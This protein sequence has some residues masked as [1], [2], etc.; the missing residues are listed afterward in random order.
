MDS[1]LTLQLKNSYTNTELAFGRIVLFVMEN[2]LHKN[3][4]ILFILIGHVECEVL[5]HVHLCTH[6]EAQSLSLPF[7]K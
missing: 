1:I 4:R 7:G 6:R 2:R 5:V 3:T